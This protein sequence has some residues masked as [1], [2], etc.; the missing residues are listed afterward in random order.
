[1]NKTFW[2]NLQLFAD[3]A[4]ATGVTGTAAESQTGSADVQGAPNAQVQEEKPRDLN[5]D[6]EAL[7]RG[8]YKEQYNKRVQ[9]TVRRRMKG[10]QETVDKYNSLV[11]LME[12]LG[13]KYGTN[14]I[15]ALTKAVEEDNG[16]WEQ[17]ASER[18]ISAEQLRQQKKLERDVKLME[19]RLAE[20]SQRQAYEQLHRQTEELKNLYPNFDLDTE[21]QNQNFVKMLRSGIDPKTA[22]EVIHHDEILPAAMQWAVQQTKE[23]TAKAV[24]A[25]AARPTE[26]SVSSQSAATVKKD[27]SKMSGAEIRDIRERVM[28]GEKFSF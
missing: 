10:T 20:D 1:M 12:L 25:N 26:N 2:M 18:G 4:A 11:P 28:R 3:G 8:E 15:A 22:F 9:E 17:E 19:Q 24:A 16:L 21:L 14:D 5:A 6:F 13:S 7:I 27:F 23:Q